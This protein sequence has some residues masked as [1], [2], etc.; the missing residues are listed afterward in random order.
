MKYLVSLISFIALFLP[1]ITFAQSKPLV[2][3]EPAW[4]THTAFDYSN[5]RL[6]DEA[7]NG[8]IN[9]VLEKQVSMQQQATYT[10]TALKI[11]S[12]S[13]VQNASE[14]NVNFDPTY[15][16][17]IFHYITIIRGG[18]S[19]NKLQPAKIKVIQQEEELNMHLYD[20][21]LSA[22]IFLE[23]VRKGDILEYSY[24]IKGSNPVFKG[25]F[26][27]MFETGFSVPMYNLYY[28]LLVPDG[29]T[30]QIKNSLTSVAFETRKAGTETSYEWKLSQ[31]PALHE[32]DYTPSWY[33]VYPMIMVSEYKNWKEV[34]DWALKLFPFNGKLSAGLQNKVKEIQTAHSTTEQRILAALHFVQDDV[35][36]LGIEMG[37][38]SH[39][40]NSPDKIFAQRFGD[41]K[42]KSYLL[43]TLLRAMGI[44]ANPVMINTG[45]KKSIMQWLPAP[46]SFDHVTVRVVYNGRFYWF[47]PTISYQRG[48]IDAISYP[49]YHC[50]LVICDTTA[51]VTT[52]P[53]Q[54]RG[55]VNVQEQIDIP[56]MSGNARLIVK[57]EY[58]GSHADG[59]REQFN[60]TSKSE[61]K[62]TFREYYSHYYEKIES[63]SL[64]YVDNDTTGKFTTYEYY[65]IQ[66]FWTQEKG[67]N[68]SYFWPYVINGI[69]KKPKD[70]KRT[71][72]FAIDYPAKY[73]EE[74]T[75]NVP[76][77][78]TSHESMEDISCSAFKMRVQF[79]SFYKKFK[80]KYEYE[81]L[82][83]HVL[84]NEAD[85]FFSSYK[86]ADENMEYSISKATDKVM[87]DSMSE[88]QSKG[89]HVNIIFVIIIVVVLF[90]GAVWF[91]QRRR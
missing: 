4:V 22:V 65:S 43:C 82:K 31:V 5:T 25:K 21:S 40:P 91:T 29:R 41:C 32:Q 84:P 71:M 8:Y 89:E 35:R 85:A 28:K 18:T 46:Q 19:I 74:I 45:F 80:L 23:D 58:T 69:F 12:E 88:N 36:Y 51:A 72:P 6:D 67:V 30:V 42:D 2:Q 83:D 55:M 73:Q 39:R 63:D 70:V 60:S 56:D 44:E 7:E 1:S 68:K 20:G 66:N 38:N 13:G 10:K 11:L 26:S 47:D 87:I 57:T 53:L 49:N 62:K 33:D 64:S 15:N 14:I 9:L 37:Q 34:N 17:L 75:I 50:G 16:Q 27:G 90:G 81:S 76:E 78:W 86:K 79:A 3:K 24:T 54:N 48:S 77:E 61:M 59:M 52:I